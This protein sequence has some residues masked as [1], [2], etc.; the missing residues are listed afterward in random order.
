[1]AI[2]ERTLI[3]CHR[4]WASLCPMAGL[5]ALICLPAAALDSPGPP[6]GVARLTP[7]LLARAEA[8]RGVEA[9]IVTFLEP[10]GGLQAMAPGDRAE[11]IARTASA[12]ADDLALSGVVVTRRFS[13]LPMM[14]VRVPASGLLAMAAD[15]RIGAVT[16]VRAVRMARTEGKQLMHVPEVQALGFNG[17]GIG[18]AILDTG[19]DYNHPELSPVGIKTIKLLDAIDN[20]DDPMD[21]Q[22]HGTSVAAIAAGSGNGV[23]PQ[24]RIVAVRVLDASGN[25]TSEQVL[26]GVDAVLAS[27][28][29]GN[30]YNIKVVN[31]SLGGYDPADW[32]PGQGSCDSFSTDFATAFQSLVNAGVLIAVAAG[33]GSCSGGVAWPACISHAIAVGAVYDANVSARSWTNLECSASG[34]VDESTDADMIACYSDSGDKL[35]VWAPSTCATTAALGGGIADCFGGTSAAAPY[36]AGVAALLTQARPGRSVAGLRLALEQTGRLIEDPRNGMQRRRVNAQEALVRLQTACDPPPAPTGLGANRTRVCSGEPVTM[37]WSTVSGVSGYTLQVDTV[38]GFSSPAQLTSAVTS[39]SY[40]TTRA[41]SAT[42]YFRVRADAAC[43]L[44]SDWSATAQVVYSSACTGPSYPRAYYVSGIA[45]LPGVPPADWYSDLAILNVSQVAAD[46]RVGFYG[47]AVPPAVTASL[48]SGQQLTLPNVLPSLFGL[49]AQDVGVIVVESSQPLMVQA[50]TYSKLVDGSVTKTYGQSYE[51][52]EIT[53]ALTYG[54]MGYLP[55]LRSDG[56]FRTNLEIVNVGDV[57]ATVEVRFFNGGGVLIGQ[58]LS[59]SAE[60]ARRVAV[61]RAL[62]GGQSSAYAVLRVTTSGARVI[63]FA[64]VVDGSSGDPTTVVMGVR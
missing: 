58:P 7:G 24:A 44:S 22:G 55:G 28:G 42:L 48:A 45:R 2:G 31:M 19:V 60:P 46:L 1:M 62:T 61:T 63:G 33:N 6:G 32:P 50:R 41:T 59:L 10:D 15:P 16:P 14:A 25:G 49:S 13:H 20:D 27:I 9:C 18:V 30:P 51:G 34:C 17:A 53:Q 56:T 11:W 3:T 54:A 8:G 38:P 40:S 36:V 4:W 39:T 23:A 35:G 12:L 37:S 26:A 47:N 43:G 29:S 52:M 5:A 57:A 21:E 64:S